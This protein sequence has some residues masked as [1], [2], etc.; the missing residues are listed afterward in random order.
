MIFI[1]IYL[2]SIFL[3]CLLLSSIVGSEYAF[4]GNVFYFFIFLF[5][6]LFFLQFN[7][8]NFNNNELFFLFFVI[9]IGTVSSVYNSDMQLFFSS[10]FLVL[11]SFFFNKLNYIFDFN[12]I[13]KLIFKYGTIFLV[14]FVIFIVLFTSD[15]SVPYFG[16]YD[17]PNTMGAISSSVLMLLISMFFGALEYN[18]KKN[19]LIFILFLLM[20]CFIN[21]VLIT[22]SRLAVIA[23]ISLF[24]ILFILFNIRMFVRKKNIFK[25]NFFLIL[26]GSI[27]GYFLLKNSQNVIDKFVAKDVGGDVFDGRG[28][29][30]EKTIN[31]TG[32]WGN[33]SSYFLDEFALGAHNTFIS[34]LGRYGYVYFILIFIF[35]L[36]LGFKS[37]KFLL[38]NSISFYTYMYF[39]VWYA[40][41]I[42]SLT[43]VMLYTPIMII[44]ILS[45][46]GTNRKFKA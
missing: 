8:L 10:C 16:I 13:E 44:F 26:S 17:N 30:W 40:F 23:S 25:F 19:I 43:E 12:F 1:K 14:F 6:F 7:K 42:L 22:V 38:R 9:T 27:F 32:F 3:L 15:Y 39:T 46:S 31:D 2:V 28:Y 4:S 21:I 35:W 18:N 45:M 11:I 20:I 33:G 24:I 37:F 5:F 34:I 36:F 41:T 29:I